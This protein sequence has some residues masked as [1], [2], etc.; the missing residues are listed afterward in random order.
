MPQEVLDLHRG[1]IPCRYLLIFWGVTLV[2]VRDRCLTD[3]VELV[4]VRPNNVDRPSIDEPFQPGR[5]VLH[6][7]SMSGSPRCQKTARSP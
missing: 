6:G 3:V 5:R 4:T 2:D 1:G 7:N